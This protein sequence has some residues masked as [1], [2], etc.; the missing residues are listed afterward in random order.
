MKKKINFNYP[1]HFSKSKKLCITKCKKSKKNFI[2]TC[3]TYPLQKY[4]ED[5]C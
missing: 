2:K 5:F 3:E 4:N 1:Y